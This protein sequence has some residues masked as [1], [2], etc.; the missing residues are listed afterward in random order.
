ME[1]IKNRLMLRDLA[2]GENKNYLYIFV[3]KHR[4]TI[5]K[6]MYKNY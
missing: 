4:E 3:R 2:T 6:V 5:M 1:N